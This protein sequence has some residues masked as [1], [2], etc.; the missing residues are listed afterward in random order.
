MD[1]VF[2]AIGGAL[3]LAAYGLAKGCVRLQQQAQGG[4]S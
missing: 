4:R 2:M 3:W 1:W